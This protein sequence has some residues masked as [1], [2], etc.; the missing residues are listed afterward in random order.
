M[1]TCEFH[2]KGRDL[3]GA[4]ILA[5][6]YVPRGFVEVSAN[7]FLEHPEEYGFEGEWVEREVAS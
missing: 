7:Q 6:R 2:G 5:H 1:H 4:V 3:Y